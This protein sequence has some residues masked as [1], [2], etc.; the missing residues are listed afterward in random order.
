[1][2]DQNFEETDALVLDDKTDDHELS[3]LITFIEGRFNR[4]KDWRRF[5]EERWLQSYRNYRGL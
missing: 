3:E 4:S 2:S 1:M 5:D